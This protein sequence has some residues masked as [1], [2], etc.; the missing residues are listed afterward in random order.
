MNPLLLQNF[1][2][3]DLPDAVHR[4]DTDLGFVAVLTEMPVS[5][6]G[7]HSSNMPDRAGLESLAC[8]LDVIDLEHL[9]RLHPCLRPASFLNLERA[10][11][12]Q[13]HIRQRLAS[14]AHGQAIVDRRLVT[15]LERPIDVGQQAREDAARLPLRRHAARRARHRDCRLCDGTDQQSQDQDDARPG[16]RQ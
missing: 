6:V 15:V 7:H 12:F 11:L 9:H 13:V 3:V 1:Y 2:A 14:D 10:A 8:F 5:E 16:E 4:Y